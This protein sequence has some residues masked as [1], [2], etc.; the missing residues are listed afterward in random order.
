[1]S[2]WQEKCWGKTRKIVGTRHYSEH[3]LVVMSGGYCS[4]HYHLNRSNIFAV[5]VSSSA[6]IRV[7]VA[8]GWS[9]K[10]RIV[11]AGE[12]FEVMP[13]VPHQFQVLEYGVIYEEYIPKTGIV[14]DS[15]IVRLTIGGQVDLDDETF[16]R[17]DRAA[18][19]IDNQTRWEGKCKHL[20][21]P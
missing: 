8:V 13:M 6:I 7:V 5:P 21:S 10:S 14:S 11:R 9:I 20:I 15:D 2:D 4:F 17:R 19:Q 18:V 12:S 16:F 3:E 1:M